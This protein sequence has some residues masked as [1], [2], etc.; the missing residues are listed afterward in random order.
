MRCPVCRAENE[1]TTCRRCRA[2]LAPLFALEEQRAH[3]LA[4]AQR[5]LGNG[6][7]AEVVHY[8]ETAQRLRGGGDALRL[9][10]LGHLL[11]RDFARAQSYY[12]LCRS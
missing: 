1:D 6:Q 3:A 5:A 10:A 11:E 8:A 7:G 12:R 4:E 9:L 2:D